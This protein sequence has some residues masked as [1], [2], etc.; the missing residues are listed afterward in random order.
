MCLVWNEWFNKHDG[1]DYCTDIKFIG[2]YIEFTNV[3]G[4]DSVANKK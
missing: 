4:N 3:I 1:I 2:T